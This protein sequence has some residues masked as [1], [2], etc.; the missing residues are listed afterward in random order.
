AF[1]KLNLPVEDASPING[2]AD[3]NFNAEHSTTLKD[4]DGRC[5]CLM[6]SPPPPLYSPIHQ[7]IM[8]LHHLPN[9]V[10]TSPNHLPHHSSLITQSPPPSPITSTH[11]QSHRPISIPMRKSWC[12][13]KWE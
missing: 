3:F 10:T 6:M 5:S 11:N 7:A 9:G 13:G 4:S 2:K 8:H 12:E 1:M